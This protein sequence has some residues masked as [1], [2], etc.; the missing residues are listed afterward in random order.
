MASSFTETFVNVDEIQRYEKAVKDFV[1]GQMDSNRFMAIRLQHGI[2]GQR[3][4]NTH[5]IRIKIPG[6]RLN[7]VQ[8]RAIAYCLAHYSD[9]DKVSVT[10]RQD[11]Q[12]HF[13]PLQK[14]SQVMRTLAHA[15]LTTREAC[16][17]TVRNM[18]ACSMAGVC[19][20]EHLDVLSL[21]EKTTAQFL[22]RPLIQHLPRK[23][24]I[25]FSG[26]EADCALGA[27][28]DAGIVANGQQSFKLFAGGGLGHKPK[29]AIMV[30]DNLKGYEITP[31]I[32]A[33][34]TLHNKYSDRKRRARS[35]LKFLVEHFG[36]D[37]FRRQFMFEF[38]R[39]KQLHVANATVKLAWRSSTNGPVCGSGTPRKITLQHNDSY[40]IPLALP[41][42]S[43]R[44]EQLTGIATLIEKKQIQEIRTT[45]DQNMLAIGVDQKQLNTVLQSLH[46]ISLQPPTIGDKVIACPGTSTCRL[47]ITASRSLAQQLSG[48]E[49]NLHIAVSGCHNSCAQ[50]HI[51]DIGLHGE[52][53][54]QHGK[55]VPSYAL[56]LGGDGK[57]HSKIG[58]IGPTIP[59]MRAEAAIKKL[60]SAYLDNACDMESFSTWAQRK[61]KNYFSQLLN[62]LSEVR[63]TDLES[64]CR[65]HGE[66]HTFKVVPL[67]GGECAG[68]AQD[69]V[70]ASFSEALNEK[71]YRDVFIQQKK[72]DEVHACCEHIFT[73]CG[74]ALLFLCGEKKPETIKHIA[75]AL[76]KAL[77]NE[78]L[79]DQL[80]GLWETL[81][82][83]CLVR[84][85]DI[86]FDLKV[87]IDNWVQLAGQRCQDL[88][89]Q[90]DLGVDRTVSPAHEM[91]TIDLSH[92]EC[93]LHF[94]KA[95][96]EMR[97][98]ANGEKITF[99]F[100]SGEPSHQVTASLKKEGHDIINSKAKGDLTSITVKKSVS[101]N[102]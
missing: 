55:L 92:F 85:Q 27:I 56:H 42:G 14:T 102:D 7:A 69:F 22:R 32:E 16:G 24:K 57:S 98:L 1:Q 82:E 23:F 11:M 99:L 45:I 60:Q 41:L 58:V 5:M 6:G 34:I 26:C 19:P 18:T 10:T 96:N 65:D 81:E 30:L 78:G 20:K 39:C 61:G 17:N 50:H 13:V 38:T 15:G 76:R 51:S 46:H 97:K 71:I 89:E 36:E 40:A 2:Y 21:V 9:T 52:G 95:R 73:L 49:S 86:F 87:E 80:A 70:A 84:N 63:A 37:E 77:P 79:G 64:V 66:K 31:A 72:W 94:V 12:L 59:A 100:E 33:L 67:G 54:R 4:D 91:R 8:C 48:G 25:S 43:V 83:A 75:T 101:S 47:G 44:G 62:K 28:H 68:A 29:I 93:P 88:D 74:S 90:L 35:R 53:K 3:Q